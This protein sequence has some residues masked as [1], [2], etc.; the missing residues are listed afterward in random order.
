MSAW[1]LKGPELSDAPV[2]NVGTDPMRRLGMVSLER[3][4]DLEISKQNGT[5]IRSQGGYVPPPL[6]G[7]GSFPKDLEIAFCAAL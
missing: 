5:L 1:K 2:I 4:N 3:L 6:V 7:I